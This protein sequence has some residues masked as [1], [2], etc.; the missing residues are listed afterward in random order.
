MGLT[1]PPTHT[2]NAHALSLHLMRH[3]LFSTKRL[4]VMGKGVKPTDDS[5]LQ[6]VE[7]LGTATP[8][9]HPCLKLALNTPI[10]S[11]LISLKV[12]VQRLAL[13]VKD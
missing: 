1:P 10:F 13:K 12:K 8:K 5:D 9:P 7:T 6:L 3:N 4:N 2:P 11:L